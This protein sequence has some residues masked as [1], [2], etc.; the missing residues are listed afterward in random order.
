MR[1]RTTL[2]LLLGLLLLGL[3][4]LAGC[5]DSCGPGG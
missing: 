5:S 3:G 1:T 2:P 4:V